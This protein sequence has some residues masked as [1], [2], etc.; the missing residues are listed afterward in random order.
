MDSSNDNS[1]QNVA[2]AGEDK[3]IDLREYLGIIADGWRWI[4]LAAVIGLIIAIYFAWKPAPTYQASSLMR[5]K[6]QSQNMAPQAFMQQAA[7]AAASGGKMNAVTAEAAIVGSR[8]VIGR[9]VDKQNLQ[10]R[11][12]PEYFPF[13]G[14]PIAR[15]FAATSGKGV[16]PIGLSGYAWGDDS[17]HVSKIRLPS[18]VHSA[19]FVL[20]AEGGDRYRLNSTNGSTILKGQTGQTES[21]KARGLGPIKIFVKSLDASKGTHFKVSYVSK[22]A[23]IGRVQGHLQVDEQPPGSGMLRLK[24][25]AGSPAMAE[26]QLD[27]IMSA[28]LDKS[29]EEQSQ[30]ARQRLKFLKKQLPKLR[31]QRDQ[32]QAKLSQYQSESGTL[33]LSSQASAVLSQMTNLDKKLAQVK[34]ERQQLLQEYTPKHPKVKAA[35]EK[36]ATLEHRRDQLQSQLKSLPENESKLVKLRSNAKVQANLYTTLLNTAQGLQVSKAG[37]T[38]TTHIIDSAYASH[39]KV[40]PRRSMI[41]G[42]GLLAGALIGV[43]GVLAWA[44]LRTTIEDP[45]QLEKRFGLPVYATVPYSRKEATDSQAKERRRLL[46]ID[47]PDDTAVESLR[48][49]RTSLQFAMI[50]GQPKYVGITG[51]TPGCGKSF[52]A[53]NTA[54]LL[55]QAGNRVLLVDGDLRRGLLYRAFGKQQAPGLSDILSGHANVSQSV[56]ATETENMDVLTTGERP[57]NPA[58]LLLSQHFETLRHELE[59]KY[60]YVLFDLPPILNVTD[61]SVIA[62]YLAATFLVV[63]SEQSTAHEVEQAMRRLERD[64]LKFSGAVFNGLKTNRM[65][66][67]YA[68]YGYYAYRY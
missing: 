43:L 16:A 17:A 65:R 30:Q 49:F 47:V 55:A 32:A 23:A 22:A 20:V 11:T 8:S 34:I 51:P 19:S 48:S 4:V 62:G 38:G 56:Q 33:D 18:H 35:N 21:G 6:A 54:I 64:G 66:Y 12:S 50:E 44:L 61:A 2:P 14:E 67:G 59:G 28:Y 10:I 63:R 7:S 31:Q 36:K 41:M 53:G 9:A 5:V 57:P 60:D 26:K 46:A 37:I 42:L 40:A 68:K 29:V 45:D 27:A 1:D 13:I 39:G 52:I 15:F 25:T 24:Y 58:E 3:E